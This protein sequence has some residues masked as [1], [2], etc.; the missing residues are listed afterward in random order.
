M[1]A[2]IVASIEV[3]TKQRG[4]TF[5]SREDIL[6]GKSNHLTCTS[7]KV[8]PAS[9]FAI[10]AAYF[11]LEADRATETNGSPLKRPSSWAKKIAQYGDVFQHRIYQTEWGIQS[12]FILNVFTSPKKAVN[13]KEFQKT[14][15]DSRS[16]LF[17][18]ISV[19]GSRDV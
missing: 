18:G 3:A 12:L 14:Q 7:G 10:N 11:A 1:I 8:T 13:V 9:L 2:D 16:M 17:R 4:Y 19:L 6:G 15:K 5:R